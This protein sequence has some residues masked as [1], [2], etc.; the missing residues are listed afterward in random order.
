VSKTLFK[1]FV[2]LSA[3]L[4]ACASSFVLGQESKDAPESLP[5]G[6][7]V[8]TKGDITPSMV[9]C[10]NFSRG[11]SNWQVLTDGKELKILEYKPETAELPPDFKVWR[12][13]WRLARKH[14]VKF[15]GGWLVGIDAGE[16]GGGLWITN[17]TGSEAKNLVAKNVKGIVPTTHGMLVF[18]GLAHL[19]ASSGD[20]LVLS[21]PHN[22]QVG[23]EWSAQLD[24][25]PVAFS[26]QP[27]ESVLVATHYSVMCV[28]PP[29]EGAQTQELNRLFW[30]APIRHY[31]FVA[32]SIARA[33]DGS[34]YLGSRGIVARVPEEYAKEALPGWS[35]QEFLFPDECR[36][37]G[38]K[39]DPCLCSPS[40]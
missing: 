33:P 8:F 17:E 29:R 3:F 23:L 37:S 15:D 6:W 2:T 16:W 20:L 22:M 28:R 18:S 13:G 24:S 4:C 5:H 7:H 38:A 27:D 10:L 36:S 32:N 39:P 35:H 9:S 21:H 12:P 26:K 1:I 40:Q 31:E 30:L 34:I 19:T 14:V 11:N 25:E